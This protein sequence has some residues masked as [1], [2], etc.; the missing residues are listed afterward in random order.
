M[1]AIRSYYVDRDD[2]AKKIEEAVSKA[3]ESGARTK[4]IALE[5]EKTVSTTQMADVVIGFLEA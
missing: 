2:I 1:Y 3:L 5:G 4:D